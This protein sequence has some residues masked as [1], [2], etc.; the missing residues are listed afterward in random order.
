M[1][2][3]DESFC[4]FER[5]ASARDVAGSIFNYTIRLPGFTSR[6]SERALISGG[7]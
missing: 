7:K 2:S 1:H 5:E 6:E 3:A 4:A